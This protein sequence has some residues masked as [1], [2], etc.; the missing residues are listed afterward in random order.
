MKSTLESSTVF[1]SFLAFRILE[2]P[3]LAPCFQK[4]LPTTTNHLFFRNLFSLTRWW[5]ILWWCYWNPL[6]GFPYLIHWL[7]V[8][9][10]LFKLLAISNVKHFLMWFH[11]LVWN[12]IFDVFKLWLYREW[13]LQAIPHVCQLFLQETTYRSHS[14]W[15]SIFVIAGPSLCFQSLLHSNFLFRPYQ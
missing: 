13:V 2:W 1:S 7:S 9:W 5:T 10:M 8:N 15:R 4:N 11:V 12:W 6:V 3:I 14:Q